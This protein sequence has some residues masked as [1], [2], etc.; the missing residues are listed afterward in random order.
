MERENNKNK[1]RLWA[2]IAGIVIAVLAAFSYLI[3]FQSSES[4]AESERFVMPLKSDQTASGLLKSQE[5]IKNN[6]GF[7]IASL[8][9]GL[10]GVEPG[11][12]K[13][14]KSMTAWQ[15]AEVLKQEPYMK[16]VVIPEGLRKE[17]I[18]D[19]L[20][21]TLGWSEKEKSDWINTYTAMDFDHTEGVYF[22][23]TYLI[24]VDEDPLDVAKRLR[25]KFE[26]KFAPYAKEAV[27]QN[28]KW[29]TLL[30]I[31]SIIQREANGHEDMPLVAGILWNR[32]LK[33]MR[34]EVDATLQYARGDKGDGWWASITTAEKQIESPYNTYKNTG[35][36]LH[37]ISNPG[38][39]AIEAALHPA[40]TTCLYYLHDNSGEI[41]CSD[42]YE[43]HET[44]IDKYLK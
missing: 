3:F 27:A 17:E 42:S 36:P 10:G 5:F 14:S 30:K 8:L 35:L 43:G 40:S 22:P 1:E 25:A 34:L 28:I 39:S 33:D 16:W 31:A 24:P 37:P 23:D 20:T 32:L 13:I 21:T 38:L 26:E 29:T 18:A 11:G 41:H 19:L 6:F 44:N 2:T 4:Q 15:I 9:R 7:W 12:Y